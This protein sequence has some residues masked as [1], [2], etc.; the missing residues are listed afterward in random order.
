MSLADCGP[1]LVELEV[2]HDEN[3]TRAQSLYKSG[4]IA[5][6]AALT[7]VACCELDVA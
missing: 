5:P 6:V 4:T 3:V 7:R 2:Y 1:D